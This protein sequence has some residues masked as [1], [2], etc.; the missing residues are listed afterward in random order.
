MT[1]GRTL[2]KTTCRCPYSPHFLEP[3]EWCKA[4]VIINAT[5][6]WVLETP[7]IGLLVPFHSSLGEEGAGWINST[8]VQTAFFLEGDWVVIRSEGSKW[9]TT[10]DTKGHSV[11]TG[12]GPL[13]SEHKWAIAEV[14]LIK[15]CV[16][17]FHLCIPHWKQEKER[18]F[19]CKTFQFEVL[20]FF[21]RR[22]MTKVVSMLR[23][24]R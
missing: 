5:V 2:K 10:Q 19:K 4:S 7:W 1:V 6:G 23:G 14:R 20:F 21:F 22:R 9:S 11:W 15:E 13:Y 3:G 18:W 24:W 16:F 8:L 17:N 12:Q